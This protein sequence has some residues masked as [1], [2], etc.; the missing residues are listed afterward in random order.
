MVENGQLRGFIISRA[1]QL[2]T[3]GFGK[4]GNSPSGLQSRLTELHDRYWTGNWRRK[5]W[6]AAYDIT[7]SHPKRYARSASHNSKRQRALATTLAGVAMAH[8]NAAGSSDTDGGEV[9]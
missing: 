7:C 9:E 6:C 4:A 3:Q 1:S 8:E 2:S 5:P